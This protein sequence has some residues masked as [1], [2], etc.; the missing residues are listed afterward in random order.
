MRRTIVSFLVFAGCLI[1]LAG[2]AYCGFPTEADHISIARL[3]KDLKAFGVPLAKVEYTPSKTSAHGFQYTDT[4][5][6]RVNLGYDIPQDEMTISVIVAT[7][8]ASD[9]S[10]EVHRGKVYY[11]RPIG[12]SAHNVWKFDYY[13]VI[14]KKLKGG[15]VPTEADLKPVI[16]RIMKI[17]EHPDYLIPFAERKG[18]S[19][20]AK[21]KAK[22]HAAAK[23]ARGLNPPWFNALNAKK[24]FGVR[25]VRVV[26]DSI[27]MNDKKNLTLKVA[28][29]WLEKQ[30]GWRSA[31]KDMV[32][33]A[34]LVKRDGRW[35]LNKTGQHLK[36]KVLKRI[37]YKEDPMTTMQTLF[38]DGFTAIY[39]EEAPNL[40]EEEEV[41]SE[42]KEET[43]SVEAPKIDAPKIDV[44]SFSF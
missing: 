15:S 42:T 13:K 3:T 11:R 44:P 17:S 19:A 43:E 2:I 10:Y 5:Q 36:R 34:K 21:A 22:K 25:K 37:K 28:Y 12:S 16:I 29:Y 6:K 8:K 4:A 9:G 14:S 30:S 39:S 1:L 7:T 24:T 27:I 26:P 23:K 41:V 40:E 32:V 38:K 35:V 31:W 33:S 20:A 18:N